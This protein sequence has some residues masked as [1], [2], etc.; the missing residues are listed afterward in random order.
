MEDGRWEHLSRWEAACGKGN[1]K[2]RTEDGN[3]K[4]AAG[5]R[6]DWQ[7]G[8]LPYLRDLS[9]LEVLVSFR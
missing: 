6:R 9:C 3:W 2:K 1:G 8:C 4:Y 5:S 7:A